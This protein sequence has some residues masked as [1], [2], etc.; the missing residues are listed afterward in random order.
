MIQRLQFLL[1]IILVFTTS[2]ASCQ[3]IALLDKDF[4]KPILYT[5]SLTLEQVT[6][7][8]IAIPV[9]SFDTLYSNLKAVK[10]LLK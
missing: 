2:A 3:K 8:L 1:V 6:S 7:N 10:E 5:D 9:N 4:K